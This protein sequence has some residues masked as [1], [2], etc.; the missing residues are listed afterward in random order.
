[1][2]FYQQIVFAVGAI[3][4]L[5]LVLELVRRRKLREEYT[6]FWLLTCVVLL[7]LALWRDALSL[8][9]RVLGTTLPMSALFGAGF[10]LVLLIMLH[11]SIVVSSL[12]RQNKQQAQEIALLEEAVRD[13]KQQLQEDDPCAS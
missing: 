9:G 4:L 7:A 2:T 1:M 6:I 13:L 8:L 5:A 3:V 10:F 12:W 11:F